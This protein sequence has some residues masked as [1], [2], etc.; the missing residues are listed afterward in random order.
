MSLP[1]L[2]QWHKWI[3]MLEGRS[4]Q[5]VPQGKGKVTQKPLLKDIITILPINSWG[6]LVL[7]VLMKRVFLCTGWLTGNVYISEQ[8]LHSM[9]WELMMFGY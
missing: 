2:R 7:K 1:T 3:Q 4:I 6:R 8:G 9:G 5:H